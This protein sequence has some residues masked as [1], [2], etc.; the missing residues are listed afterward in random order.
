MATMTTE[1]LRSSFLACEAIV[2][3]Q[4]GG[5]TMAIQDDKADTDIRRLSH[6]LWMSREGLNLVENNQREKAMHW[7]GFLQGVL[8]SQKLVDFPSDVENDPI[9]L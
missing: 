1:K 5:I 8:W 7:L 9:K 2:A 3:R 6:L 4:D